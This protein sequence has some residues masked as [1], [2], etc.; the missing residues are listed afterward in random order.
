MG[1]KN[2]RKLVGVQMWLCAHCEHWA[3]RTAPVQVSFMELTSQP[4]SWGPCHRYGA[5]LFLRIYSL[6]ELLPTLG[7]HTLCFDRKQI[8]LFSCSIS[9]SWK[10][11]NLSWASWMEILLT[12]APPPYRLTQGNF[13]IYPGSTP[14]SLFFQSPSFFFLLFR[15][16][17][18]KL[19]CGSAAGRG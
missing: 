18:Q 15:V 10:K 7:S 19:A 14:L 3:W 17:F 9:F 6:K 5:I 4:S 1:K 2:K 12:E 8:C 11:I 13:A 16:P